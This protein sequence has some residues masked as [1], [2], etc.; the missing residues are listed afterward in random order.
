MVPCLSAQ[1]NP[2]KDGLKKLV[3][4]CY[5]APLYLDGD[6][7]RIKEGFHEDFHMYVLYQS[8]FYIRTRSEWLE[9]IQSVRKRNLPKK[10]VSWEFA[11]I[12]HEG[13][14]A[15]VKL[16]LHEEGK[17]KY[18]DYLTLYRFDSGWRVI[19]KQFSMF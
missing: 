10:A 9:D 19:T 2:T 16:I 6:L 18:I 7:N 13:Q 3:L 11:H 12:D 14:T 5:I 1:E 15:V 17:L 4:E 8:T